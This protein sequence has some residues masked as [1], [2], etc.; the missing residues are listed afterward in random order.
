M[1]MTKYNIVEP[2][3][4]EQLSKSEFKKRQKMKKKKEDE[5][6]KKADKKAKTAESGDIKK[7]K[8]DEEELDPTKYF[9]NRKA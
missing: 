5:E 8:L 2:D 9:E 4:G 7:G 3:T 6:K 1:K